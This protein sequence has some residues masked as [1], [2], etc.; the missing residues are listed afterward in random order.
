MACLELRRVAIK[1]PIR[2]ELVYIVNDESTIV[3]SSEPG[4]DPV[5]AKHRSF[6]LGSEKW[7]VR[8]AV[9]VNTIPVNEGQPEHL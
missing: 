6:P 9:M 5:V 3:G 8:S 1:I 7:K 4:I 2:I